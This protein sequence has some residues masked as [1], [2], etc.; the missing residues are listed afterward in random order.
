MTEQMTSTALRQQI[1]RWT[2]VAL[3]QAGVY[4]ASNE[5]MHVVKNTSPLDWHPSTHDGPRWRQ[6]SWWPPYHRKGHSSQEPGAVLFQGL[7]IR[8]TLWYCGVLGA[9]LI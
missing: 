1:A 6:K 3:E 2:R 8:L 5:G 7:R 9:A 4:D